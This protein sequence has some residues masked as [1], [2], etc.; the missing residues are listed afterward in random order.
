VSRT[1]DEREL[2]EK[3]LNLSVKE[4]GINSRL[5]S[6]KGGSYPRARY[7]NPGIKRAGLAAELRLLE[8]WVDHQQ[9]LA[10]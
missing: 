2:L 7:R 9:I 8:W 5:S 6:N 1:L 4:F 10:S 3:C